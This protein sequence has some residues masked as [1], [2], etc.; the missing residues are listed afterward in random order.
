MSAEGIVEEKIKN[1]GVLLFLGKE[2]KIAVQWLRRLY[3]STEEKSLEPKYTER[4]IDSVQIATVYQFSSHH[5]IDRLSI[6]QNVNLD[7]VKSPDFP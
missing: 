7:T 2:K 6:F 5:N 4:V 1:E 3:L